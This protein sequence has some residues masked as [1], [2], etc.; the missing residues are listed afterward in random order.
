MRGAERL[1]HCIVQLLRVDRLQ[2]Q[3]GDSLLPAPLPN[4]RRRVYAALERSRPLRVP[5]TALVLSDA[6]RTDGKERVADDV[7]RFAR[8]END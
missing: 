1:D 2:P 7:E 4:R 5:G 8:N 6:A 3:L